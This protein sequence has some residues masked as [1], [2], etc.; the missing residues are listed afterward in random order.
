MEIY[1]FFLRIGTWSNNCWQSSFLFFPLL[2][3]PKSCQYILA[4]FSCGIWD[5]TSA[6]PDEQRR[7]HTQ[8]PNWWNP[9][10][11]SRAPELNHSAMGPAPGNL[12]LKKEV[13]QR[14]PN[15]GV[16]KIEKNG[17]PLVNVAKE[18]RTNVKK[19]RDDKKTYIH[20]SGKYSKDFLQM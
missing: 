1:F 7:V 3:F 12:F 16:L 4:Y 2:F 8:D 17:T 19:S 9:G 11:P 6:L 10:P 20:T 13:T 18:K 14:K 5:T 15:P